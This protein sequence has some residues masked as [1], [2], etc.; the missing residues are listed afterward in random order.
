MQQNAIYYSNNA[1]TMLVYL[2]TQ[3]ILHYMCIVLYYTDNNNDM[4]AYTR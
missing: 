4:R 1:R 3:R 2:G